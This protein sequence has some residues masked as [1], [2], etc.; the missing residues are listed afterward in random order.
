MTSFPVFLS[1]LSTLDQ[2]GF[3]CVITYNLLVEVV[4]LIPVENNLGIFYKLW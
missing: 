3:Q 4:L 2:H 1:L